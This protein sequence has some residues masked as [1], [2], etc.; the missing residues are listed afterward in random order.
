[1]SEEQR[2]LKDIINFRIQKLETLRESGLDPYPHNFT[3]TNKS[4][5]LTQNFKEFDNK[6]IVIA[7]RIM[8]VRKMGRA[9]FFHIQ[10]TAGRIQIYI[11]R[12]KVGEEQYKQ[13]KLLDIGDFVGVSGFV[14]KTK[15]GEIS[16]H[17]KSITLLAKSIRPLP[18]VKEKEGETFD[19]FKD[20][21]QRY[22]NRHLD[23]IVNPEIKDVFQNRAKITSALRKYLD[24]EGF[25]EVETPTLF[26]STPE[27]AREF[28]VPSRISPGEFYALP[29]SPQQ[30][31]QVLMCAGVDKYFQLA[32]CYR[33]EDLRAD[34]QPEFTQIDI[35]M[36]FIDREDIYALIEGLLKTIWKTA[37]DYDVPTP[38]PRIAYRE[39][40]DRYGSDK[41][42]TRY[43]MEIA[44][45]YAKRGQQVLLLDLD[46][47]ITGY[48]EEHHHDN[49]IHAHYS[50]MQDPDVWG[51]MGFDKAKVVVSCMD[52]GQEA[53][54]AI[55]RWLNKEGKVPFIAATSSH[56]ETLE[57]YE[58]GARYVIQTDFLA[59]KSFRS[60]FEQ[61]VDKPLTEAFSE[62]GKA[63]WDETRKIKEGMGALFATV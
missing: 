45:F 56:E 23:L 59:A 53:E 5:E 51:D 46:P 61:E 42:D 31:K 39:V 26:K 50:D 8:A 35:E 37:L 9:S 20:K 32:R 18:I 48:F 2:S 10:D 43:A 47:E 25:L 58:A 14:F 27:G 33:D 16:V 17:A 34:R 57:L 54:V 15:T 29:Q 63:H 49:N 41:P 7:G 4:V 30:F 1:M 38:F 44:D 22:R 12:D 55:A 24:D 28:L 13:F 40:M 19:A 60:L 6:D 52:G 62:L 3:P 11:K 36:S 21:E